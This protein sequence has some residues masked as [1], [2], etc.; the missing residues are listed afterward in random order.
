MSINPVNH[1]REGGNLDATLASVARVPA[2]PWWWLDSPPAR[3]MTRLIVLAC[4][5]AASYLGG[6]Q[7]QGVEHVL[8][9]GVDGL[10]PLGLEKAEI[11]T[12][13]TLID[14]GAHSFT[15]RG[16]MPTTS[17]SNWASMIMG[18]GPEQHGV[19]SNEWPLPS[20]YLAPTAK[21]PGGM[22]PTIFGLVR[23]QK[24]DAYIA[25][26]HDWDGFGRLYERKMVDLTINGNL[27]DDTAA[28]A[29]TVIKEQKPTFLFVHFDHVDHA[30]HGEGF[31][32][33]P[34]IAAVHKLDGLVAQLLKALK[35]AGI[36]ESTFILLTA[37]HGGKDKGHGGNDLQEFTIPWVAFGPGVAP[38]KTIEDPINTY[39]TAAT[40]AYVF[41]LKPP[42]CWIAR[43][44]LAAFE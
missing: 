18:A 33:E 10:G 39:D 35:E 34:Y 12:I 26:V 1:S 31:G 44:V 20:G 4:L 7:V 37:D 25:V 8:V 5:L 43:P 29:V 3:G 17:S 9:I 40:I 30:L 15:A 23:E 16:V 24:P 36:F 42:A 21:G 11:P 22:F 6:A 41:G 13:K 38:G 19:L 27:E 2:Q 32:T 28:Q 14:G